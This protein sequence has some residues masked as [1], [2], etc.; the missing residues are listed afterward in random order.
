[1]RTAHNVKK[2]LGDEDAD[3]EVEA[4]RKPADLVKERG[5]VS[6]DEIPKFREAP[7]REHQRLFKEKLLACREVYDF[8]KEI[9]MAD[10][11]KK[12]QTLMELID[13]ASFSQ[14]CFNEKSIP[15][16]VGMVSANIFR[17]LQTK[18]RDP[19]AFADAD[20][21]E[22]ILEA[23]WPHLQIIYEFFLRFIVSNDT[24]P[25]IA[26]HHLNQSFLRKLLELFDS[27]DPRERDYLKTILHRFYG[28]FMSLRA[29]L[30]RAI[31]HV[32][33]KVAYECE[34]H[35]GVCELLEIFGS[36]INGFATPLKEEHKDFLSQA[37]LPLLKSRGL[38]THFAQLSYCLQQFVEKDPRLSTA[39]VAALLRFWPV[40]MTS[41]QVL[42]LNLLEETLEQMQVS[43][44]QKV[45]PAL[46]KRMAMC[47]ECAHF[48]VAE[49]TLFFWNNDYI[50]KLLNN[51]RQEIFPVI[52]GSLQRNSTNHWNSAVHSLTCNVCN[53]LMAADPALFEECL[54][55]SEK[56]ER[57]AEEQAQ[58]RVSK[59]AELQ[60]A[61]DAKSSS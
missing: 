4:A 34:S 23:S 61:F 1:M 31:Q 7:A 41:K 46:I 29:F 37:L 47:F 55:K 52:V 38:S 49:R 14:N 28:K 19:L 9:D 3:L 32:F 24:D 39:V 40:S 54:A 27:E 30:R 26:K 8:S 5:K 35:N 25:K 51:S 43:D 36:I 21:D 20:E 59:W 44:F 11:D 58:L 13:H 12:R 60:A 45:Q 57:A 50:T 17:A 15:D 22:P 18:I 6:F 42:Y 10:K 53:L 48:Q 56:A 2:R 16:V 33:A